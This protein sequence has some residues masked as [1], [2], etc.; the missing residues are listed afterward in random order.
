M[1]VSAQMIVTT[2]TKIPNPFIILSYIWPYRYTSILLNESFLTSSDFN[3]LQ[4][5]IFDLHFSYW[6]SC[7]KMGASVER[8]W[9][10]VAAVPDKY[11]DLLMPWGYMILVG[12]SIFWFKKT[13]FSSGHIN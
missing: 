5:S 8:Y 7:W 13:K 11:L 6:S 1:M 2:N 3:Y 4:S 12:G 9:M 10:I